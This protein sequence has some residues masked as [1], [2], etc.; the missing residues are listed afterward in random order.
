MKHTKQKFNNE[1]TKMI[2]IEENVEKLANIYKHELLEMSKQITKWET[3][4]Q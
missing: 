2:K 4:N 1:A 3:K